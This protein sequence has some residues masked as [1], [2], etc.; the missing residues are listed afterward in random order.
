[1]KITAP[2]TQATI[3]QSLLMSTLLTCTP[4]AN[5]EKAGLEAHVHGIAE[6]NLVM[7]GEDLHLVFQSPAMNLV[8]FEHAPKTEADHQAVDQTAD[9]LK[10]GESLFIPNHTASCEQESVTLKSALLEEEAE[11]HQEHKAHQEHE[12]HEEHEGH[13]QHKHDEHHEASEHSEFLA[14]YRFH[15]TAPDQLKSIQVNI[16]KAFPATQTIHARFVT[17]DE[18]GARR[19]SA[20]NNILQVAD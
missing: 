9:H 12:E 17:Q 18:Q 19:L 15:C 11:H 4:I 14:T 10:N 6:I 7:E 5:A 3:V 16:F 13:D 2:R 8:G 1:M 20:E